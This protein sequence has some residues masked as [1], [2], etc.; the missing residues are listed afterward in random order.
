MKLTEKRKQELI[1]LDL[2]ISNLFKGSI[3]LNEDTS[4]M[5]LRSSGLLED[6]SSALIISATHEQLSEAIFCALEDPMFRD[7]MYEA[8]CN[9]FIFQNDET[10]LEVFN[11]NIR[12]GKVDK[13]MDNLPVI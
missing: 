12:Q 3:K 4:A 8:L 10:D 13:A 9:H 1:D 5:Y 2:D 11:K 7:C 6:D